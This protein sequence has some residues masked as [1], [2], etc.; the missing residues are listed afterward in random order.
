MKKLLTVFTFIFVVAAVAGIG[1]A[2]TRS[3]NTTISS[4]QTNSSSQNVSDQGSVKGVEDNSGI[5]PVILAKYLT[6]K[7]A[8]LYG[9]YWCPHCQDQKK[10]LGDGLKYINYVECDPQGDNAQPDK[11]T[12]AG[13]ESY[14]TWIINGQKTTGAKSLSQLAQLSGY[15][16]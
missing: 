2:I 7:G 6:E 4:S 9:A 16:K 12:A 13:I 10:I 1:Y 8:V 3:K 14:P 5:D 15:Q 11:C